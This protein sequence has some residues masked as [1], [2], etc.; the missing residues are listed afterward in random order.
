MYLDV[1]DGHRIWWEEHGA[2]HGIPVVVLHGGPGGG[3]QR[4][5]LRFFDL[6]RWR[7]VLFDQRGCGRSEPFLS[8]RANTTWH[9]VEDMEQLRRAAGVD[10]W[11]VFGGSWGTTLALAYAT[12]Y[13]AHVRGMILRGVCLTEPW[14]QDW[15]YRAGGVSRLAP[16][17]WAEFAAAAGEPATTRKNLMA[18]Y[19]RRLRNRRTRKAAA[20]A[21]WNWESQLST[22]KPTAKDTTKE[23][24]VLSLAVLENHY[25]RNQAW[26]RS[27]QLLRA[28]R[29]WKMPM[30]IV[31]GRYDLVC[32]AESA[33]ALA[34]AVPHAHLHL[35]VAGHAASEPETEKTLRFAV[36]DMESKVLVH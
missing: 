13:A 15:M 21:W 9:L 31:Q 1:G 22:L 25:F 20:R 29:T 32:P 14:E 35:T 34:A 18:V 16:Q 27:G 24:Q 12:R 26:L 28:A 5:V 19:A 7:V 4:S 3:L 33:V 2:K 17:G 30:T 8:T 11:V 23:K 10:R 6:S 36:K